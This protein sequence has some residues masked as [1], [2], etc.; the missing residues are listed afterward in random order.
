[1]RKLI[2]VSVVLLLLV[3][4][5]LGFAL[6]NLNDLV[7]AY[8]DELLTQV[9][10]AIGR[11]V[12]IGEIGITFLGGIGARVTD[13]AL[14]D[15]PAFSSE[16][17]IQAADLQ[18]NVKLMPLLN[19]EIEVKR[20]ILHEPVIRIIRNAE[21]VLNFE[22][23]ASVDSQPAPAGASDSANTPDS[24]DDTPARA[25]PLLVSLINITDG[26]VLYT[27]QQNSTTLRMSQ[28]D[29]QVADL[30]FDQ[31]LTLTIT[32]ALLADQQNFT[33]Q[34][35]FGPIGKDVDLNAL[36]VEASLQLD[37]LDTNAL[38]HALPQFAETLPPGLGLSGP[39]RLSSR[40][41][42]T[43]GALQLSELDLSASVLESTEPNV[44]VTGTLGPVGPDFAALSLN[45]TVAFEPIALPQLLKFT[46]IT[47]KLPPELRAEGIASVNVRVEGTLQNLTVAG[48]VEATESSIEFGDQF[49]KP[50][51]TRMVLSTDARQTPE[52]VFLQQATIR[53]HT[54]E[55]TSSGSLRLGETLGMD[56]KLDSN[57][58]DLAGWQ[59]L[60]PQ[61]QNFSPSGQL[62]IHTQFTGELGQSE[63]KPL[64]DITGTLALR[65]VSAQLAQLPQPLTDVNATVTFT[66][67]GAELQDTTARI[68]QSQFQLAAQFARFTPVEG[69][70]TL[71][72][73][74]LWLA[75]LQPGAEGE[76]SSS[77]SDVLKALQSKGRIW[78]E[79]ELVSY[80]GT[81]SS[82]QGTVANVAYSDFQA[83]LSLLNRVAEI[84]NLSLRTFSGSVSAEGE[85]DMGIQP[86][87]FSLSSQVVDIQLSEVL[88]TQLTPALQYIRGQADID[89][90][91]AG[92]GD[93]WEALKPTL[94]GQGTFTVSQGALVDLNIAE[95]VLLNINAVPGLNNLVSQRMREK[96]PAIFGGKEAEFAE[97][98]GQL[99]FN[100]GKIVLDDVRLKAIDYTAQ[101][102][103]WMDYDQNIDVRGQVILSQNLSED[104][105]NDVKV[106]RYISNQNGRVA[107]P[108]TLR[109]TLPDA[110]P[111]PD[112]E[113]LGRQVQQAGVQQGVETLRKKVKILDEILPPSQ[114]S[115]A[116]EESTASPSQEAPP[117]PDSPEDVLQRGLQEGLKGLFGR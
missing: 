102:S 79:N 13:F 115:G 22:S 5:L 57:A 83:E 25:L 10:Q 47:E 19:Q 76:P 71:T 94:T 106:A 105:Q 93:N 60:L 15:D 92:D 68:G 63:D 69:T 78:T 70:Y 28:L 100:E 65:Q 77:V 114:Q 14:A 113:M 21:G 50:S 23:L 3:G 8:K 49:R 4:G 38:Q 98:G 29:T 61:L 7:N 103:G 37:A 20:V 99:S 12:K 89:I 18:I 30:S 112:V 88:Q 104:L 96:Y 36:V 80:T 90:D 55:L 62:E 73:P 31:P 81:V 42:G 86:P 107:I 34:G 40:L 52:S 75:D 33:L 101:A 6:Y 24:A 48:T 72:A 85:Y 44:K 108:F 32:A 84:A 87:Q 97:L 39:L 27:D 41:S 16:N 45:M 67:Q 1:M 17:F 53:L 58:V 54:L 117:P 43:A 56:L 74:E 110:K 9:E 116:D 59:E 82:S 35:Q 51:G 66:G 111:M 46:P 64:P 91:L 95:D 2:L 11:K 26:E 109:G